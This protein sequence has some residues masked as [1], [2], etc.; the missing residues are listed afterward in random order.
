MSLV[1]Y[2][3]YVILPILSIS[4]ILVFIRFVKGPRI[5]DRVV[6]LDQLITIAIAIITAYAMMSKQH[7]F[8]DVAII[9][10]LIGFLGTVAFA[11]YLEKKEKNE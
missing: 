8:L 6:A 10:A 9:M 7:A 4:V 3:Q 1:N 2:L 5:T 11:Y